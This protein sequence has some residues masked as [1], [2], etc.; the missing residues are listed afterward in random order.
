[1]IIKHFENNTWAEEFVKIINIEIEKIILKK[2]ICNIILTGG[3]SAEIFYKYWSICLFK[4]KDK[5]N[6][7]FG[8]ERCVNFTSSNSNY[9]NVINNLF[10]NK[11]KTNFKI[12]RIN[13]E[14]Q[15]LNEAVNEYVNLLPSTPDII[16]L[17][18]GEDCHI[19]SLFPDQNHQNFDKNMI[20][21]SSAFH[22]FQRIS[23]NYPYLDKAD[24]IYCLAIGNKKG[25]ALKKIR[26]SKDDYNILPGKYILNKA[27]WITD[28]AAFEILNKSE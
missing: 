22:N 8:D 28:H 1:M 26:D 9:Y 15:N 6:F 17:S 14:E 5:I 2:N 4:K 7:Y 3:S 16:L 18:L 12:H 13:T 27:T 21:T 11:S 19:A 23:I 25:M 24:Q 20:I 10:N